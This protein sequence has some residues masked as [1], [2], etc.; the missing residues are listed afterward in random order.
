MIDIK[1]EKCC[2]NCPH[3]E[4]MTDTMRGFGGASTVIYCEHMNVCR[5]YY[6]TQ[7]DNIGKDLKK[8]LGVDETEP[9]EPTLFGEEE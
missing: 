8:I 1:L 2:E 9:K 6:S 7:C 5:Y 4:V 3:I